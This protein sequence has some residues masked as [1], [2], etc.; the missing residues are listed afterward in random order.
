MSPL[1][2]STL[3]DTHTDIDTDT[4]DSLSER[5]LAESG[6]KRFLKDDHAVGNR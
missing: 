5:P 4:I 1:D 6:G 3:T 2:T